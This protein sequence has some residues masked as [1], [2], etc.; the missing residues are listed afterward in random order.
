MCVAYLVFAALVPNPPVPGA[1]RIRSL[2]PLNPNVTDTSYSANISQVLNLQ[3]TCD[4]RFI[5]AIIRANSV[6]TILPPITSGN[7]G[8]DGIIK[9]NSKV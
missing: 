1:L 8:C 3:K 4:I 9:F 6:P 5:S 2:I 7:S